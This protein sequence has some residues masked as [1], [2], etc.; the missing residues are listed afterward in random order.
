VRLLAAT[1]LRLG[2]ALA[3]Q[4]Q[5]I[6][7]GRR[8][9]LVRRRIYRG[10]FAPPKSKYGRRD[11]P[12]SPGLARELWKARGTRGPDELVFA[13][14]DGQPLDPTTTFRIVKAA[15]T[16]AGA[17]WAGPHALRH[18]CATL[19]F[20][21][22]LNAKQAQLWLGHHSPAFTL[23][24]YIHLLPDDIPEVDFLDELVA[25]KPAA[26]VENELEAVAAEA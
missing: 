18:T 9:V 22:G 7:F 16:K 20:R 14:K 19:L 11:V 13:R 3:L 25:V 17:P 6:D 26:A 12:L 10:Q 15:A 24:T 2:E 5:H 23:A 21:N 1:G 8:R 4:W